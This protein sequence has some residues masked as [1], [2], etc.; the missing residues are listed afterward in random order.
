M[1]YFLAICSTIIL[2]NSSIAQITKYEQ[3]LNVNEQWKNQLD[4][5]TSLK[6]EPAKTLSEQELIQQ[7]LEETENLL[8]TR[9]VKHL[10]KLQQEQRLK[11]LDVLHNY[12]VDAKFPINIFHQNRQPY[13][14]DEFNTYC[15]VG[16]LMKQS[17]ADDMAKEI[18]KSQNYSYIQDIQHPQLMNWVQQSGFSFDELALIQ[19]GYPGDHPCYIT[20][21]HYNNIG[22]DVNEYIEILNTTGIGIN[23]DSVIFYNSN[24][25]VYKK[26]IKSQMSN[27]GLF[28]FYNFIGGAD[29]LADNGKISL[30]QTGGNL[31]SYFVYSADSVSNTFPSFYTFNKKFNIGESET[32]S[33]GYSLNFC[34]FYD[35]N[36]SLTASILPAT[37]NTLNSCVVTPVL[38]NSFNSKLI[39]NSIEL[40]WQTQSEINNNYFEIERSND[41]NNF[42]C[43]GKVLAQK[44]VSINDYSFKDAQ[45]NFINHYRLKQID[46]DGKFVY[47]KILYVKFPNANPLKVISNP[48]KNLLLI[49]IALD[50]TKIKELILYDLFGRKLKSFQVHQGSQIISLPILKTG[51]YILL[52]VTN[53]NESY[54]NTFFVV[55]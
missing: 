29:T 21:I 18:H 1:K 14:I 42:T 28:Y 43:I 54:Q 37:R 36:N 13:F 47:S 2:L 45:P 26:L 7:H 22:V 40:N 19:P 48:S 12:W 39:E 17:G 16:Y 51:K 55:D 44:N 4:I 34:G 46:K 25:I 50:E 49:N 8:R 30:I 35:Y 23:Y 5:N 20:E 52:Q 6:E 27:G 41:G 31:V 11:L 15:A 32:T 3:L 24:N 9:S 53:Q 38:L 10:N 33:I